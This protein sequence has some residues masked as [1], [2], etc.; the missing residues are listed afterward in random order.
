MVGA[1]KSSPAYC[2][3]KSRLLGCWQVILFLPWK[4]LML[5]SSTTGIGEADFAEI[6]SSSPEA[7]SK[8]SQIEVD[9]PHT[10]L[11][12][13]LLVLES[14]L[15]YYPEIATLLSKLFPGLDYEVGHFGNGMPLIK[16]GEA[17]HVV[18]PLIMN[19][20]NLEKFLRDVAYLAGATQKREFIGA[21]V[22]NLTV[23]FIG[24]F[25]QDGPSHIPIPGLPPNKVAVVQKQSSWT[26]IV[27]Q[28]LETAGIECI[29]TLDAHSHKAIKDFE[30]E[31]IKVIN[32]TAA[33]EILRRLESLKLLP[34]DGRTVICGVDLGNLPLTEVIN[35]KFR[36]EVTVIEKWRG[37]GND[38][39]ESTT[40]QK[41][42]D[43]DVFGKRVILMD[44]MISSGETLYN[45]VQLL[46]AAGAAE[47]I[48]CAT[49]AIFG[50]GY[51]EYLEKI[52]RLDRVK[53]VMTTNSFP[54]KRPPPGTDKTVPQVDVS[55]QDSKT[56][57][58]EVQFLNIWG[59]FLA[60]VVI[61]AMLA[62][63]IPEELTLALCEHV[64]KL[65]DPYA[66]YTR[67]TDKELTRPE[68]VASFDG[69]TFHFFDEPG[70]LDHF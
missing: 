34:D 33:Y 29:V 11:D 27:A 63:T 51:S 6:E 16:I 7:E 37:A 15:E 52:L 61:P 25:R 53:V 39:T 42:I 41:L 17:D 8:S 64:L 67:L 65:E 23:L 44:D 19:G 58:R 12:A 48:V 55:G 56:D 20:D 43:G 69:K 4:I 49:H 1:R 45:T 3:K 10:Q 5:L 68:V 54:L 66:V 28:H 13:R 9:S 59:D 2:E 22:G 26:K 21:N 46:L 47:V 30:D 31:G 24:D 14:F 38:G 50:K 32:V 18:A 36:Y 35:R 62:H 40:H 57:H 70:V 60:T